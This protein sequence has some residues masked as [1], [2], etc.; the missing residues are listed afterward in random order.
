MSSLVNILER[1]RFGSPPTGKQ[2]RLNSSLPFS[3]DNLGLVNTLVGHNGCVNRIAWSQDGAYLASC[4]DDLRVCVWSVYDNQKP[5]L[6]FATSHRNN[7]FGIR[8]LS[9]SNNRVIVTGAMDGTVELHRLDEKMKRRICAEQFYCHRGQVKYIETEPMSPHVFFSAGD[10]GCIRQYDTRLPSA[11]C[12]IVDGDPT[13]M[14]SMF[15]SNNCIVSYPANVKIMS[16]RIS[17]VDTN[18][19]IVATTD[20]PV[21]LFDRRKLSLTTPKEAARALPLRSYAP[22]HIASLTDNPC[23]TSASQ[24]SIL[25]DSRCKA[26]ATYAE[27][28]PDGRSI[29]AT[30][31]SDHTYVFDVDPLEGQF[32]QPSAAAVT[33]R[34]KADSKVATAEK[35]LEMAADH[36]QNGKK[37]LECGLKVSSYDAFSRAEEIARKLL[38]ENGKKPNV[39]PRSNIVDLY[40]EVLYQRSA[41]CLMRKFKGDDFAGLQDVERALELRPENVPYMLK[42]VEILLT[43]KR[44]E[45]A[46]TALEAAK[47]CMLKSGLLVSPFVKSPSSSE[48]VTA[49]MSEVGSLRTALTLEAKAT[50]LALQ[51]EVFP[52]TIASPASAMELEIERLLH[53]A[54]KQ[55]LVKQKVLQHQRL[56]GWV[57][58]DT[59]SASRRGRV[60]D[61][62]GDRDGRSSSGSSTNSSSHNVTSS[63]GDS[64]SNSNSHSNS[65]NSGSSIEEMFAQPLMSPRRFAGKSH[66]P[67]DHLRL[68]SLVYLL[69]LPYSSSVFNIAVDVAQGADRNRKRSRSPSPSPSFR[70]MSYHSGPGSDGSG[71]TAGETLSASSQFTFLD[72]LVAM[73]DEN[74]NAAAA[75]ALPGPLPALPPAAAALAAAFM[76]HSVNSAF[77]NA[78]ACAK[79]YAYGNKRSRL[80]YAEKLPS[81]SVPVVTAYKQRF[82]GASNVASDIKE[83][84][85]MGPY[86]EVKY[87]SSSCYANKHKML[88]IPTII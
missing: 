6:I 47:R 74:A 22:A 44:S 25:T 12:D 3:V 77:N 61:L 86:G 8:F 2:R 39:L 31:L 10:D 43:F 11:G 33:W 63:N 5:V 80:R 53:L 37:L 16:V 67:D 26:H 58:Y 23:M 69:H 68:R 24:L 40:A 45:D 70:S 66:H 85:F 19:M 38:E 50:T 48:I 62:D 76:S 51:A 1:S 46:I 18:Y 32:A 35:R 65:N 14:G 4:S 9:Q 27:F 52:A 41:T 60:Q 17:P 55:L 75:L 64:N 20:G 87:L 82:I 73:G 42:R 71:I 88:T 34:T 59:T 57:N 56:Q 78:T 13:A 49:A 81:A 15:N 28:S 21:H 79:Y 84:I 54:S 7:I 30:Y 36:L 29:V 83:A 72:S